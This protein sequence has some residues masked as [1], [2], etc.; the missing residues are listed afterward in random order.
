MYSSDVTEVYRQSTHGDVGRQ[1]AGVFEPT[2]YACSLANFTL[3]PLA[4]SR[5]ASTVGT[6]KAR[7]SS[8]PLVPAIAPLPPRTEVRVGTRACLPESKRTAS[9]MA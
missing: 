3:R 2:S 7:R 5:H 8:V 9:M 4:G 1:G 6:D